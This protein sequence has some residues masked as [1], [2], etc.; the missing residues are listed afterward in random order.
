MVVELTLDTVIIFLSFVIV[1]FLL[2]KTFKMLLRASLIVGAAFTFPWIAQYA[3]LPIHA[4]LEAGTMLAM[5]G[6]GLFL[7]YEFF[8][9]I[10]QLIRI[11]I[12]PFRRKRASK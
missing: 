9:F 10:T 4:S 7:I 2:Y 1:V 3:G 6:F 11:I 5:A 8:N 12:W